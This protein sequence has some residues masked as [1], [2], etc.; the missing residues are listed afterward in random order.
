[1]ASTSGIAILITDSFGEPFEEIRIKYGPTIISEAKKHGIDCFFIKGTRP[2]KVTDLAERFSNKLRYSPMWPLQRLFDEITLATFR[3]KSPSVVRAE[4]QLS[5]NVQEGLRT[6]GVKVLAGFRYLSHEYVY[7]LKIT[8]SSV[9]NFKVFLKTL[10]QFQIESN[11]P[12]YAGSIIRFNRNM[13]FVSGANL[14][15]NRE[16]I[17]LLGAKRFYWSHGN[18]DDVAIGKIMKKSKIAPQE[19][20]TLN[21]HSVDEA[22]SLKELDIAAVGHFRCKSSS[23]PRNDLQI[24]HTLIERLNYQIGFKL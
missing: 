6:L 16:S 2:S 17:K 10:E 18:L 1:M 8:S 5:V 4:E 23:N 3:L 24:I 21:L 12:L 20:T 15:L 9:I 22:K 19:M 14:L 13:D 7:V 11:Q